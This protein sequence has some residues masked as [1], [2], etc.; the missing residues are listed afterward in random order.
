M[1]FTKPSATAR[2][3]REKKTALDTL[4]HEIREKGKVRRRDRY[5]RFPLCGCRALKLRL[6]ARAEVSHQ[7]HKGMG[8]NPSGDRSLAEGMLLLCVHRHQDGSISRHKG[9]LRAVPLT[10]K[11]MN[12]PVKWEA[13]ASRLW[14]LAGEKWVE[15]ARESA[16]QQLEPLTPKQQVIL[17]RLATMAL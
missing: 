13:D 10:A 14:P 15:L 9:T 11:G 2:K 5:C 4:Q 3:M 6:V 8:G 17:E 1:Q 12:G 16:V 7:R